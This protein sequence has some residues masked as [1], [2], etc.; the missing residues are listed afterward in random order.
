[1]R[2]SI[3]PRNGLPLETYRELARTHR[4]EWKQLESGVKAKAAELRA[5]QCEYFPNIFVTGMFRY[6]VA[7]NRDRQEN[8]FV[9]D[10]FNYLEGGLVLGWR[11]TFDFG[12]PHRVA[13]K[14]AEYLQLLQQQ[15]AAQSGILLDV[16]KAY[17]EA[18]EKYEVLGLASQARK[19]GRA[20]ATT[21]AAS[22]QLGLGEAKDVFEALRIYAE[23]AANYYLAVKDYNVA[24]AELERATGACWLD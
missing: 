7:P 2:T 14:K 4:P 8:P 16:E 23:S 9:V 6:A 19:N 1:M 12:L 15:Q 17:K 3:L 13:E 10:D 5:Q 20:L 22:F 24:V 21:S 18:A 11:Y